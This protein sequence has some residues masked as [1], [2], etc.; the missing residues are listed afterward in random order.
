MGIQ[1]DF[2]NRRK[3]IKAL[4]VHANNEVELVNVQTKKEHFSRDDMTYLVDERAIYRFKGMPMLFYKYNNSSPLRFGQTSVDSSMKSEEIHK[5]L[6]TKVAKDL[7]TAQGG[8]HDWALYASLA[9]AVMSLIL[10][11][12]E[13]GVLQ[14]G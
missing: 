11:M 7:I 2:F 6:E 5:V 4:I 8:A 14:L 9:A 3:K 10:V 13:L 12:N 1:F